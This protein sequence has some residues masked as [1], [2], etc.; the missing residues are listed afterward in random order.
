MLEGLERYEDAACIGNV[1]RLPHNQRYDHF[2]IC[3]S[4]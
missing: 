3:F 1:Q 2:G 4:G